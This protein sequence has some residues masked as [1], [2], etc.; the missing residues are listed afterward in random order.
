MMTLHALSPLDGRYEKETSPLRDFFSEFAYL[1]SRARLELDFL[2]A[3]S[4][5]GLCPPPSLSLDTFTDEDARKIQE[6]EQITRHDVKAIEYFLRERLAASALH[7]PL[8]ERTQRSLTPSNAQGKNAE[9]ILPWLHFGLTSEDVNNIAQAL[10]LR[11]SRDSVLLPAL[12]NLIASLR[13][14]AKRYRALPLLARTH[15]Q[16]A[17]PTTF[18]KEIA[19]YLMRLRKCREEIASHVFEAKLTGAVGNFN[20]LHAA[21][22]HLDWVSFSRDFIQSLG[23]KPNLFTTQILPYDN[24]LRYFHALQLTNS[25]LIDYAQDMWRYISDGWLRQK[26]VEGEVGSSTMPQK[27]N[28]IDFENAEGNLGIAN[29]LLTHYVQKLPVSR[30]QRDLSDSTVRRTFGVALGHTLLAWV[31]LAKGMSRVEADEEKVHAALQA[32][33][34]VVSEGAQTILRAAGRS[35]AYETLK[36]Q[37]RGRSM[38]SHRYQVWVEALDVDEATRSRLIRLSPES[39]LGLAVDLVDQA[40]RESS[41]D[42][43]ETQGEGEASD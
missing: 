26:V 1:R 3:L 31:N 6:Y 8:A 29:A 43:H 21:F 20:A 10:A 25:I 16:P 17:V 22:P 34:E 27:V 5:T 23:L 40:L 9:D 28:P 24:W 12:D 37:T 42:H 38:D 41:D 30:L 15:G 36:S 18:G 14:F 13:S 2:T 32:H 35:D 4:K 39:Y 11:D 7:D 19:V 33:W